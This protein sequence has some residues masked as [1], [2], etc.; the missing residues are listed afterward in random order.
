[1]RDILRIANRLVLAAA[2]IGAAACG[3]GDSGGSTGPSEPG[4]GNPP[5]ADVSGSYS[6]KQVRSLGNLGGGG[7]GLPVTFIDGSGDQLVFLS[8]TLI[9]AADGTFDMKVQVTF[10]GN[11][12]ELTDYGTY[13]VSGGGAIDFDSQK[14]T[15]R[16]STGTVSGAKITA[17]SQFG[18]IP[19]EIDVER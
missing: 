1:M 4:P 9:L 19:F 13:S 7:S 11:P 6:L 3:G 17:H 18:G 12:S 2:V 10:K 16:L 14:S 8:G 5:P 15:P